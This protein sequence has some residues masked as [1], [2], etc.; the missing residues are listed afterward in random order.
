MQRKKGG[1]WRDFLPSAAWMDSVKV[2][3]YGIK[4][5]LWQRLMVGPNGSNGGLMV[6][7]ALVWQ[8]TT[9]LGNPPVIV[10]L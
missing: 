6:N 2:I 1:P 8:A 5:I 7:A 10:E 3:W 4:G 9:D